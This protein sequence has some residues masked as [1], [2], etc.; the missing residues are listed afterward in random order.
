MKKTLSAP[1]FVYALVLALLTS[2]CG[3]LP[4]R[5][6]RQVHTFAIV[7]IDDNGTVP[8][9]LLGTI[10][11]DIVQHLITK[12]LVRPG[13]VFLE[14]P[15]YADTVFRVRLAGIVGGTAAPTVSYIS[16]SYSNR[17]AYANPRGVYYPF[18]STFPTYSS[19]FYDSYYFHEYPFWYSHT[20]PTYY[21]VDP[22]P[23]PP[24]SPPPAVVTPPPRP[25]PTII[26]VTPR[27]PEDGGHR[28]R[29]QPSAQR[30]YTSR[31]PSSYSA[32]T[33]TYSSSAS[34]SSSSYSSSSSS[35]SSGSSSYS[36]GSSSY[37]SSSGS[38]SSS[39]ASSSTPARR[40]NEP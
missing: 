23:A 8:R 36:S 9:S 37:S 18:Y 34:S 24:P 35:Y 30:E 22:R 27:P 10:E 17:V 15:T 25:R 7:A 32:P 29:V 21:R 40:T 6:S 2:G 14:E 4:T 39:S 38:S 33:P 5:T 13:E 20:Y 3:F 12:G 31:S 19:W 28:R 11:D 1:S 26:S 16:P